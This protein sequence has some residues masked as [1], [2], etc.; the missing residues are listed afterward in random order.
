MRAIAYTFYASVQGA[1][2]AS[3]EKLGELIK[4]ITSTR[5]TIYSTL[6]K[7]VVAVLREVLCLMRLMDTA[8]TSYFPQLLRIAVDLTDRLSRKRIAA[9]FAG[10]HAWQ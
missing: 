9:T 8:R 10:A 5:R 2:M 3:E 4:A 6:W 7:Y 1:E